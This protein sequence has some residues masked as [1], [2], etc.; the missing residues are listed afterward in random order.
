MYKDDTFADGFGESIICFLPLLQA[1][2]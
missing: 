1:G 2:F